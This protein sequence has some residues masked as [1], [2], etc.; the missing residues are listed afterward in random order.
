MNKR[1]MVVAI[2]IAAL[3]AVSVIKDLAIKTAVEAGAEIVTGLKLTM[4]GFNAGIAR[5]IVS[6]KG[7]KLHNPKGFPDPVMID[8]PEIYVDYDL[9]AMLRGEIHLKEARINLAEFVVVKD[10][11]GKL[12]LN[13]L[14]AVA[15]QKKG[16]QATSKAGKPMKMRIDVLN[17][18][19]GKAVYKDYSRGGAP[20]VTEY[21]INIDKTFRNVDNPNTL[22]SLLVV[23]AL[24]KT[25]IAGL[26]NFDVGS[27]SRS[28]SASLESATKA[29]AV[30]QETVNKTLEST[31]VA[32]DTAKTATNT[33]KKTVESVGG[34]LKGLG[35][36]RE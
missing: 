33:A 36:S 5:S 32:A 13:S 12:N 19:I 21:N 18:K 25:P 15:A 4:S 28:V 17:L 27:L 10:R 6:I 29:V 8:M 2:V 11:A 7:L 31:K 23:E 30:A 24:T 20:S 26:A 35:S 34:L 16:A 22:V 1:W 9:P 14:K 3:V